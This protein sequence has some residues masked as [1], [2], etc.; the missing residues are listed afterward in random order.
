[1]TAYLLAAVAVLAWYGVGVALIPPLCDM[2]YAEIGRGRGRARSRLAR[3]RANRAAWDAVDVTGTLGLVSVWPVL[4]AIWAI[5]PDSRLAA[6]MAAELRPA[7][8]AVQQSITTY[9][10]RS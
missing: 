7:A 10:R 6:T 2:R 9:L 8:L 4:C 3:L 1:M 5:A